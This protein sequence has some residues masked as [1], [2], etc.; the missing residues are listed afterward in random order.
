MLR[1]ILAVSLVTLAI[2]C[3]GGDTRPKPTEQQKKDMDAAH[4]QKLQEMGQN[5][6]GGAAPAA[7]SPQ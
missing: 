1:L 2:G 6:G 7:H 4:A 5:P 3:G